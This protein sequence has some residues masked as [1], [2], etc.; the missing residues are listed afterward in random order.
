M[1]GWVVLIVLHLIGCGFCTLW[2]FGSCWKEQL[3]G[4]AIAFF[5]WVQAFFVSV[6]VGGIAD[7]VINS[8]MTPS[9]MNDYFTVV[10]MRMGL[11]WILFLVALA[12]LKMASDKLSQVKVAFHP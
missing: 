8:A 4:N 2:I 7:K 12:G 11:Q 6:L 5:V 1:N 9:A 3:W 10:A